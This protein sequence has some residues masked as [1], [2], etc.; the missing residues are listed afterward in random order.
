MNPAVSNARIIHAWGIQRVSLG[1]PSEETA[2]AAEKPR[3]LFLSLFFLCKDKPYL[4]C[5]VITIR[6]RQALVYFAQNVIKAGFVKNFKNTQFD[7]G[8]SHVLWGL[9]RED[10]TF[11]HQEKIQEMLRRFYLLATKARFNLPSHISKINF[12]L[13]KFV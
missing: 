2:A 13:F 5:R 8:C 11:K 10:F 1:S 7:L 12:V 4:Y 3:R 6:Q 9:F